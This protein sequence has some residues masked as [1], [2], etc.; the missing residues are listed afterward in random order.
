ML[1]ALSAALVCLF[2]LAG[3]ARAEH[4][5][6]GT[7]GQFRPFN[8]FDDKG[9]LVGFDIEISRALCTVMQASCEFVVMDWD[10]L[11]PALEAGQ[12]DVIVASMSKTEERMKH[13]DFTDRYYRSRS[14]FVARRDAP[15][16]P[17]RDGVAGK[18]LVTQKETVFE[19]W[20]NRHF[21][22][23]ASIAGTP[24]AAE[25]FQAVIDRKADLIL[26]DNLV[27]FEVLSTP[28]GEVLEVVGTVPEGDEEM[29]NTYI[30]V[31]KGNDRLRLAINDALRKIWL[32]GIYR[33][34]NERYFPFDIY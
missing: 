27:A 18:R 28:Q 33:K 1:R 22:G 31:R 32:E 29:S 5:R 15:V 14:V 13:A 12:I 34:I 8:Y 10:K 2:A 19:D 3:A 21:K 23:V 26:I 24:T 30:Q 9:E 7:E 11:L 6:I 25:A 20:L 17:T 16:T 4:L